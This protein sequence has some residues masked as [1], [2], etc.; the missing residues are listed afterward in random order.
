MCPLAKTGWRDYIQPGNPQQNA[1]VKRYNR[2]GHYDWLAQWLFESIE[3][4][5]ESATRWLWTYNRAPEHGARRYHAD[6]TIGLGRLVHFWLL[7]KIGDNPVAVD[8]HA[9]HLGFITAAQAAVSALVGK[10]RLIIG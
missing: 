3:Q 1:Y 7:I 4:V 9:G 8:E 5:Q 6:A 10:V 2:T